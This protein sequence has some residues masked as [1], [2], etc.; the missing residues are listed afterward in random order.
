MLA[1]KFFSLTHDEDQEAHWSQNPK[2]YKH[3]NFFKDELGQI[4]SPITIG[5]N[6][7][8]LHTRATFDGPQNNPYIYLGFWEKKTQTYTHKLDSKQNWKSIFHKSQQI[9]YLSS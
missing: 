8:L 5:M 1:T 3:N 4:L 6:T 7:T 2:V 9:E